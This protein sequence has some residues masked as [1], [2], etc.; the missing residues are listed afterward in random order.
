[1]VTSVHTL[2]KKKARKRG[3]RHRKHLNLTLLVGR[4]TATSLPPERITLRKVLEVEDNT[5]LVDYKVISG[6][7][8]YHSR[9]SNIQKDLFRLPKNCANMG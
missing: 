2:M 6:L 8:G 1:M 3:S 5:V 9:E 7:S 4:V